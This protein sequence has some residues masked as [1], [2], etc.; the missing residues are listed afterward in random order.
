MRTIHN[1][2]IFLVDQPHIQ[3]KVPLFEQHSNVRSVKNKSIL[4]AVIS[5]QLLNQRVGGS[6]TVGFL[7]FIIFR[8]FFFFDGVLGALSFGRLFPKFMS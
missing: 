6:I 4:V 8:T 2:L 5:E 3:I 1:F 7:I